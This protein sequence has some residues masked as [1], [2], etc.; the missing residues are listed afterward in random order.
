[1]TNYSEP[2]KRS[3]FVKWKNEENE[4]IQHQSKTNKNAKFSGACF[5]ICDG[6]NKKWDLISFYF[7]F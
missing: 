6:T 3:I 1:M 4:I 7:I 5:K 2:A